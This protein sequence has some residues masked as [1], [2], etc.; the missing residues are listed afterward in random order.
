M[1]LILISLLALSLWACNDKRTDG[2]QGIVPGPDASCM[3]GSA[4]CNSSLYGNYY[5]FSRYNNSWS[6]YGGWNNGL[7]NLC[8]CQTG[9]M[10]TY[11]SSFGLGCV[12]ASNYW[13]GY[14]YFGW[15]MDSNQWINIPS[16]SNMQGSPVGRSCYN[17][18]V[19]SCFVNGPNT[20]PSGTSC[21]PVSGGSSLG[22]CGNFGYG[23]NTG[24]R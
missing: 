14:I 18:V 8:G 21:N 22:L 15:G 24:I 10:P 11:N 19:Q 16:V 1:R 4:Y 3:N 2:G 9:Y 7:A 12:S 6:Y 13:G 20:C 23:T 17:G 5:G